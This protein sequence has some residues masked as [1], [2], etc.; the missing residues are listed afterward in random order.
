MGALDFINALFITARTLLSDI[1][2]FPS[3]LVSIGL[4][5]D[6]SK[7]LLSFDDPKV[8]MSNYAKN[9]PTRDLSTDSTFFLASRVLIL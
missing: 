8:A 5:V 9:I 4:M 6:N 3:T 2:L 7:Y 1:L